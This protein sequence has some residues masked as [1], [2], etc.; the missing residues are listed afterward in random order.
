MSRDFKQIGMVL[1]NVLRQVSQDAMLIWC[2]LYP[3]F[4]WIILTCLKVC[5][6]CGP[7]VD[8]SNSKDRFDHWIRL[9]IASSSSQLR[10]EKIVILSFR[11]GVEIQNL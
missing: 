8:T 11:I 1:S 10:I 7:I 9:R 6:V 2:M 3:G 4:E 5:K